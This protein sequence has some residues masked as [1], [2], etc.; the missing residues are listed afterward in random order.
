MRDCVA[1]VIIL[2]ATVAAVAQQRPPYT[3]DK[4]GVVFTPPDNWAY[5]RTVHL[6]DGGDQIQWSAP[7]L[8]VTVYAWIIGEDNDPQSIERRLNAAIDTKIAQRRSANYR[9]YDI[10]RETV[11]RIDING[12]PALTA[13]AHFSRGRDGE[14]VESIAWVMSSKAHV[15]VFAPTKSEQENLTLQP[16]FARF[17]TS[18][19]FP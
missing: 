13:I 18:I 11:R 3:H 7:E 8:G 5:V 14:A 12:H 4:T 16:E 1:A 10:R 9:N 19:R 2:A 6:L 17:L 15:F